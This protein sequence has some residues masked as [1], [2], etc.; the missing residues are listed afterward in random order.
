MMTIFKDDKPYL[1]SI[2]DIP[3]CI[4]PNFTRMSFL[5]LGKRGQW[6][7]CKNLHYVSIYIFASMCTNA[8]LSCQQ[9]F[10]KKNKKNKIKLKVYFTLRLTKIDGSTY[11]ILSSLIAHHFNQDD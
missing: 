7:S 1:V 11:I 5:A 8:F 9:G 4:C 10:L 6:V 2:A 3:Q